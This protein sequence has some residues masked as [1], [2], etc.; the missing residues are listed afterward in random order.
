MTGRNRAKKLDR[1]IRAIGD[2]AT[3]PTSAMEDGDQLAREVVR[4]YADELRRYDRLKV[5]EPNRSNPADPPA[6]WEARLINET[7]PEEITFA[8]IATLSRM[9]PAKGQALWD[10][11][12]AAA[13]RDVDSGWLASRALEYLGG[14]AWERASFL[15]YRDRLRRAWRPRNDCESQWIDE[16]AQYEMV[17]Q[18]WLAVWAMRSREPETLIRRKRQSEPPEERRL[19]AADQTCE[20]AQMVERAQRLLQSAAKMLLNMRRGKA[21]TIFQKNGQ[22]NVGLGP[23]LNVNIPNDPVT[24][25]ANLDNT[26]QRH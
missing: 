14:S 23:Q 4:A 15:A 26:Q 10:H 20:A 18:R 19:D 17:R 1:G 11:V 7:P 22:L 9:D 16:M 21:P 6:E 8:D 12:K 25:G 24:A 2:V 5:R 13:L 3:P